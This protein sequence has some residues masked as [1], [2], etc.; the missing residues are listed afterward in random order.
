MKKLIF[1]IVVLQLLLMVSCRSA[2]GDTSVSGADSDTVVADT[3]ALPDTIYASASHLKWSVGVLDSTVDGTLRN[4]DDPYCATPS[5]LTFR[6]N[7]LRNADF[8]GKVDHRPTRIVKD[9]TFTTNVDYSPTKVGTWGGGTGWTGQPLYVEWPSDAVKRFKA[10]ATAQLTADFSRQEIVVASLCGELYFINF[11]TGKASR[12]PVKLGNPVKGTPMVDPRYNG[13]VYVGHGVQAHGEVCQNVVDLFSHSVAYRKP[14]LDPKAFRRWPA[15]DSSPIYV[16]GFVFWPS[17]NGL[18]Y[19]YDVRSGK[20]KLHSYLAYTRA[21]MGGAGVESSMCVYKNYGFLGD[22]HGNILCINLCN[23]KPVWW[24]DN[25]DDID[26]TIVCEVENGTPYVYTA[27]EVD[28]Q[29]VSGFCH[30]AKLNALNGQVQWAIQVPCTKM[31]IGKKHFDG[32]MYSTPLLGG[33]DCSHLIFS[34]LANDGAN[35]SGHFYAFDKCTGKVA[36]KIPLRHYAWS[37][38][39]GFYTKKG[40]MFVVVGDT[41][42]RLYLIEGKTGSIIYHEQ[43]GSNFESS[44]VVVG[45]SLVVGSRGQYIYK[46]HIE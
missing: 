1:T 39:V 9:W 12:Q 2:S 11:N 27:C 36:Y 19:K 17:E 4:F 21:G 42:G 20:V 7:Q 37:S 35:G 38:P 41:Y 16:D 44:P 33:G 29:G 46:L 8:G 32:G 6:A 3:V 15:S 40:E 25:H 22:N 14:G 28:R 10:T 31:S 18:I 34:T 26:A 43:F 5:H 13:L 23:M 45:N 30:I 24:Y